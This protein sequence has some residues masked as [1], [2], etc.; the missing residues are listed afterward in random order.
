MRTHAPAVNN[1]AHI[2]P[3][4]WSRCGALLVAGAMVLSSVVGLQPLISL[5]GPLLIAPR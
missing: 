2:D 4:V 5:R 1:P 3:S